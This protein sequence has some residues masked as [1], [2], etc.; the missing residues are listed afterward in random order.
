MH[1]KSYGDSY[2][3]KNSELGS[4][5]YYMEMIN[6]VRCRFSSLK[7]NTGSFIYTIFKLDSSSDV[8]SLI[9]ENIKT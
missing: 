7:K 1:V 8:D 2:S 6:S 9:L 4:N 3:A 5:L